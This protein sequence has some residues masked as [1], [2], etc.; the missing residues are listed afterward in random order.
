[1]LKYWILISVLVFIGTKGICQKTVKGS[2]YILTQQ[3]IMPEF[4]QIEVSR[5]ITAFIG[6]DQ[7]QPLIIEAD[8]NLFSY[9]VTE[10]K[11]KTLKI[12]IPDSIYIRKFSVMNIIIGIPH[13]KSLK[14]TDAASIE[15]TTRPWKTET[16]SLTA[17]YSGRIKW[18]TE[19]QKV[20]VFGQNQ[21]KIEL[22]GKTDEFNIDLKT[23]SFLDAR[24]FTSL[25]INAELTGKS[26]AYIG[27]TQKIDYH[28]SS[29]SR[30]ILKDYPEILPSSTLRNAK[31][32]REK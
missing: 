28:L 1:M 21:G 11:D 12:T 26:Q 22:K 24:D 6:E 7:Q 14:A 30:L 10:V 25:F 27:N 18:D 31:V 17:S 23:G 16:L 19:A 5:S 13:L 29:R 2:G 8:D 3:R 20:N 9:I 15:L 4:D 32:I